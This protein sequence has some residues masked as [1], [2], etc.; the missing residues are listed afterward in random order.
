MED[1]IPC[2]LCDE[3]IEASRY[4]EHIASC[5]VAIP[6]TFY[7]EDNNDDDIT[8]EVADHITRSNQVPGGALRMFLQEHFNARTSPSRPMIFFRISAA[9]TG[10]L[11][12]GEFLNDVVEV[13]LNQDEIDRVSN[14]LEEP[15]DAMC[16]ICQEC[17]KDSKNTGRVLACGHV[18]CDACIC[19]WLSK[20]KKCPL[21]LVDL[22]DKYLRPA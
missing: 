13:G 3:L 5:Q 10:R 21:C 9:M 16:P 11:D 15:G 8:N 12:I 2:E 1:M 20:H 7:D 19:M 18:F 14:V 17:F 6:L 22:E 4:N